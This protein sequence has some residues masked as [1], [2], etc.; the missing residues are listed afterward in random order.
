M[1]NLPR[2][3]QMK[4]G[5]YVMLLEMWLSN[6]EC[7]QEHMSKAYENAKA[8]DEDGHIKLLHLS[9]N[10]F[11]FDIVYLVKLTN[12]KR[13]KILNIIIACSENKEHHIPTLQAA[14]WPIWEHGFHC[15]F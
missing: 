15:T 6:R 7:G 9:R 3:S 12:Q 13:E 4:I 5:I 8:T 2:F 11:D 1:H 14:V 10:I